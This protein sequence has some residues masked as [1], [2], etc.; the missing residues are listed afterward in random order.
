MT[1][2][3]TLRARSARSTRLALAAALVGTGTLLAGPIALVATGT[4]GAS[5]KASKPPVVIGVSVSQTGDFSTDGE[6]DIH[7]Y[8]IWQDL[9]NKHGGILGRKVQM[10]FVNDASS[11]TQVVTNYQTLISRD[12]VTLVFG[13]FSSEL[14]IPASVVAKRYGYA[15]VEPSGGSKAVFDRGF[16][17]VFE[18]EPQAG[19]EDMLTYGAWLKTLPKKDRPK[20]AAYATEDTPFIAPEVQTLKQQLQKMGVKTLYYKVY[21]IEVPSYSPMALAVAHTK[22]TIA[23]LGTGTLTDAVPFTESFIQQHYSPKGIVYASGPDQGTNWVKAIGIKNTGGTAVPLGWLPTLDTFGNK[24]F[25]SAYLKKYGGTAAGISTDCGEAYSVGQV[26]QQA[27][28]DAHSFTNAKV[29]KALHS[30]SFKTVQGDFGFKKNGEPTGH[31]LLG[32]WVNG[33]ISVIFPLPLAQTKGVYPKPVWG[34]S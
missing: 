29:I 1:R 13:P 33:K 8:T 18:A 20:T 11:T 9:V 10:K 15:F 16:G 32:Q 3:N 17:N 14:T 30:H 24:Q 27:I 7:A 5:P 22:A 12:H 31:V 4:A 21:P 23:V 26:I 2:W 6:N 28:E 25:V 34:K 19:Y